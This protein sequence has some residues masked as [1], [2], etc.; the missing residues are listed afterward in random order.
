MFVRPSWFPFRKIFSLCG[1]FLNH[2]AKRSSVSAPF[3][4][5]LWLLTNGVNTNGAAANVINF[6]KLG[7]STL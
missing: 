4:F 1:C 6:D 3:T 2:Q 5:F 7:K